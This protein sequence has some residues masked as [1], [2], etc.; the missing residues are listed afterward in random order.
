MALPEA[1]PDPPRAGL[2]HCSSTRTAW[3]SVIW[4]ISSRTGSD[5]EVASIPDVPDGKALVERPWIDRRDRLEE[6]ELDGGA[7]MRSP[8]QGG[9]GREML[10][11]ARRNVAAA[12]LVDQIVLE[13]VD[14]KRLPYADG[15]FSAVIS[16]SIVHHIPAP[17]GVLAD[18]VRVLRAGG[19]LFIRDLL[20]PVDYPTLTWTVE[21]YTPGANAHQRQMFAD[22]V[23]EIASH[24]KRV[25]FVD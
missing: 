15:R 6:V 18:A 4:L 3:I 13:K 11:V 22:Q 24:G 25:D 14:A 17:I 20:R 16:N 23:R 21:T 2:V 12:G 7:W 9:E 10:D 1:N 8:A 5:S 19:A